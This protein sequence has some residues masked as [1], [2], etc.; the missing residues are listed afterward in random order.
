[1]VNTYGFIDRLHLVLQYKSQPYENTFVT[2]PAD[3]NHDHR[4]FMPECNDTLPGS[5]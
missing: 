2:N 4:D 5:Q 3:C 1:M